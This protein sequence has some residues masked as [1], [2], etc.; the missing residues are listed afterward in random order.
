M[1]FYLVRHGRQ[2]STLYNADVELAPEGVE[3]ANLL[4]KR[5]NENYDIDVLYSSDYKRAYETAEIV[6]GY[7]GKEHLIDIRFREANLGGFTGLSD[8]EVREKYKSFL[9][10]RS[11]M[12][13][14]EHY[15]DG[16]ENCQQIY[17]RVIAG[18]TDI[19]NEHRYKNVCIVMHGGAMRALLTGLVGAPFAKWLVYGRQIENCSISE[20]YYDE[21]MKT[22]HIER[23]NDYSHL[24]GKDRLLRRHFSH[25]FFNSS[26]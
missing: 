26:E 20:L 4:G 6:N 11:K 23:F 21:V 17:E 2:N 13:S 22:I 18:I 12:I 16:G 5:L 24:E 10:T 15:P 1:N 3:Q 8:S 14:D 25:G 9:D 19:I 7:I